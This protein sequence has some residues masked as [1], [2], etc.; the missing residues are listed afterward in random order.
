M[1]NAL[2]KFTMSACCWDEMFLGFQFV[3]TTGFEDLGL[4]AMVISQLKKKLSISQLGISI[5]V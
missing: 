2:T 1:A 3:L 5:K 4:I